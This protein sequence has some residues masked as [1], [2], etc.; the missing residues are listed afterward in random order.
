MAVPWK[1]IVKTV[2]WARDLWKH[3]AERPRAV[4]DPNADADSRLLAL[5]RRIDELQA[6]NAEQAKLMKVLA[7]ELQ[8]VAR[9]ATTAY[10]LAIAGVLLAIASGL[11][12][13]LP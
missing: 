8:G 12:W 9:R 4:V 5:S 2:G 10:R 11:L 1:E 7:E 13:F 3:E 6:T